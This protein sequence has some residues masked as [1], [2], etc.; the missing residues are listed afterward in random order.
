MMSGLDAGTFARSAEMSILGSWA[1]RALLEEIGL[2]LWDIKWEFARD[3]DDLVFVDTVDTDSFRALVEATAEPKSLYTYDC[4]H[5]EWYDGEFLEKTMA[6]ACAY[7]EE[8]LQESLNT[9]PGARTGQAVSRA[10]AAPPK[11]PSR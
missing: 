4:G 8:H 6:D 1:V 5:Y 7:F 9:R 2:L 10:R 3:G 11:H